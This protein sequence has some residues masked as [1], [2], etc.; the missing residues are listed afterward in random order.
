MRTFIGIIGG[1]ILGA[2]VLTVI[3]GLLLIGCVYISR[4]LS[5]DDM[6]GLG[7]GLAMY[8]FVPAAALVGA[9]IGGVFGARH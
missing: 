5:S 6:A 1:A 8:V 2:A 9:I 7:F 3:A 4:Q